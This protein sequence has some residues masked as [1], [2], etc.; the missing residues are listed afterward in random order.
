MVFLEHLLAVSWHSTA[1]FHH[2]HHDTSFA[3]P[4]SSQPGALQ[5]DIVG[6]KTQLEAEAAAAT[7]QILKKDGYPPESYYII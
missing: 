6:T 2:H 3:A 1:D 4:Q 5:Y 7:Q